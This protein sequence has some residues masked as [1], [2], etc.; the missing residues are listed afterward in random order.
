M[1]RKILIIFLVVIAV[2]VSYFLVKGEIFRIIENP[3]TKPSGFERARALEKFLSDIKSGAKV[4]EKDLDFFRPKGN[5]LFYEPLLFTLNIVID[6]ELHEC[7]PKILES[8]KSYYNS[9]RKDPKKCYKIST[10]GYSYGN[11]ISDYLPTTHILGYEHTVG[12]REKIIIARRYIETYSRHSTELYN[13]SAN[14][15]YE[16]DFYHFIKKIDSIPTN[17]KITI[18]RLCN[19]HSGNWQLRHGSYE[20]NIYGD[21]CEAIGGN[22]FTY[23]DGCKCIGDDCPRRACTDAV[24]PVCRIDIDKKDNLVHF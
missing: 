19:F 1:N 23:P 8:Y 3:N 13:N 4:N 20:C 7:P 6:S 15:F 5:T 16:E 12:N 22:N 10:P 17:E 9:A 24:V 14:N 2:F 21:K 11:R 18:E